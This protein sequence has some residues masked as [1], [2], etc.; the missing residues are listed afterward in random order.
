MRTYGRIGT[1]WVQ[2]DT[3]A[4]GFEDAVWMT[5]LVQCL[6]LS[7][8]E[9]PFFGNYG[10]PAQQSVVTQVFPDFYVAQTQKQFAPLFASLI[11]TKI[12]NPSPEYRI[13]VTTQQGFTMN[14]SVPL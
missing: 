6:K 10:I 7:I 2:V 11:V 8:G 4:N 12:E 9:S 3:D 13:S 14:A 1:Q 5:T